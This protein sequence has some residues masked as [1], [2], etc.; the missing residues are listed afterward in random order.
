MSKY[1]YEDLVNHTKDKDGYVTMVNSNMIVVNEI[2]SDVA[3]KIQEELDKTEESEIY[4][5][6]GSLFGTKMLSATGPKIKIKISH[7]GNVETD[8][9]SEFISA[10]I[11][12]TLHK[13]YLEVKC[14]VVILTPYS[15]IEEEIINQVLL[16]EAVIVGIVPNTYLNVND[17]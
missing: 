2:I 9:R 6:L 7:I 14:K 4:I 16:A 15:T 5:Y 11:N 17:K 8:L 12:Q 13:I 10:G 1:K 3:I